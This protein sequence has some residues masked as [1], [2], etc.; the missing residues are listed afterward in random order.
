MEKSER[1]YIIKEALKTRAVVTAEN[2]N[3][4]NGL[5]SAVAEVLSENCPTVME[6]VG[7]KDHFGE[8]GKKD[9]LMTKF[10]LK[11]NDIVEAAKRVIAK[12]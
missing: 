7:V 10:G 9:F 4:I 3:I 12:K 8:V 6:R 5:G 11:A 1:Q 2:H